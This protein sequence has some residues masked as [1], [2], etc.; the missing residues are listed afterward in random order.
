MKV[1]FK[2]LSG[3]L[4][5]AE[6]PNPNTKISE[7]KK[8][9]IDN[10][11]YL[12]DGLKVIF[13]GNILNDDDTLEKIGVGEKNFLVVMG[14]K[15]KLEH[16]KKPEGEEKKEET[17]E[18]KEVKQELNKETKEIKQETK[19][20]TQNTQLTQN[21]QQQI[22]SIFESPT[23]Q[24]NDVFGQD[25]NVDYNQIVNSQE[26][27][28]LMGQMLQDPQFVETLIQSNPQLAQLYQTNPEVIRQMLS[29]PEFIQS[30]MQLQGMMNQGGQQGQEGQEGE[31]TFTE[32]EAK[33]IYATQLQQ[34]K[35]MGFT[36]ESKNIQAIV[37]SNGNV[38]GAID[39]LMSQM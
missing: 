17:K 8:D 26:Y 21:T 6:F 9:L 30:V 16:K 33:Q 10:Q 39:F 3:Q 37:R 28:Q 1:Q 36:D 15:T 19:P 13:N 20:N 2:T 25:S 34:L 35:D 32:D 4:F 14:K 29:T 31:E 27:Q 11:K 7:V 23:G 5:S 18:T 12:P 22:P 38:D 24:G